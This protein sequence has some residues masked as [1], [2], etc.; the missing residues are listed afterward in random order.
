MQD[1][2]NQIAPQYL[3]LALSGLTGQSKFGVVWPKTAA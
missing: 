2:M 1:E 3:Q